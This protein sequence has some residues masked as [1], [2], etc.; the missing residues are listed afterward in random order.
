MRTILDNILAGNVGSSSSRSA[1]GRHSSHCGCAACSN[2]AHSRSCLCSAC[3]NTHAGA[4]EDY[5]DSILTTDEELGDNPLNIYGEKG[6]G[7]ITNKNAPPKNDLVVIPRAFGGT[8]LIH[9]HTKVAWEQLLAAGRQAGLQAPLLLP[10]S[11]FRDLERQAQLFADAVKRYGSPEAARRWVAPP[12]GSAHLSGRTLDLWLGIKNKSQNQAA[13]RRTKAYLWLVDNA[14]K[15][16]F[17]PYSVEPWHWE[18]N[19]LAA[20]QGAVTSSVWPILDDIG[21]DVFTAGKTVLDWITGGAS[22]PGQV[23]VSQPTSAKTNAQIPLLGTLSIDIT[24]PELRK[25]SVSKVQDIKPYQFTPEDAVWLAR[26]IEGEASLRPGKEADSYAIVWAMF[27]RFGLFRHLVPGW[28]NKFHVYL[29]QYSTP[30]Q[31]FLKSCGAT[32]RVYRDY[33]AEDLVF[34]GPFNCGKN[35]CTCQG[36]KEV[37][38][39]RHVALQNKPWKDFNKNIRDTVVHLLSG[40]I[41]NPGIGL[42]T[43]FASSWVYFRDKFGH[44]PDRKKPEDMQAWVDYTK[45]VGSDK[46][47]P[48]G[49]WIWIGQKPNLD[50]TRNAF[51][52][53]SR[54]K[55]VPL[56]VVRVI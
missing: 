55:N 22:A 4:Y 14:H 42:A 47:P 44:Y 53:E 27:N 29:R 3:R 25:S 45:T 36:L 30:L 34:G 20:S 38:T 28:Q 24:N 12:R 10:T 19:P 39:K 2:T 50:Q 31:P 41:P 17:Y 43:E 48:I 52:L 56:T 49:P 7:R 26:F 11:G 51:F 1:R 40:K 35:S 46:K 9:R 33:K 16:G 21:S 32:R 18:H 8:I 54:L 5:K 13:L 23:P 6:G 15:F 37:Q